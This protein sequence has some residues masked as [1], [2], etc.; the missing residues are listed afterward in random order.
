MTPVRQLMVVVLPAYHVTLQFRLR[1]T[2][3]CAIMGRM[4]RT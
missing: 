1:C 3:R 4:W 2:L